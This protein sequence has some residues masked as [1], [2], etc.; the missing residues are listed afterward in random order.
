MPFLHTMI[1]YAA[2]R[3]GLAGRVADVGLR[4][5]KKRCVAVLTA[6]LCLMLVLGL[7]ACAGSGGGR[8]IQDPQAGTVLPEGAKKEE[9]VVLDA[10]DGPFIL[11]AAGGGEYVFRMDGA[12]D[13][14]EGGVQAGQYVRIWY[15]GVL[16]DT[17]ARNVKLLRIEAA[18]ETQPDSLSMG[19]TADGVVTAFDEESIT[20]RTAGGETYTFAAGRS[21]RA[22]KGE[23]REGMWARVYFD[24]A[25]D[26]AVVSRV[27]A[28]VSEGDVFTLAGRIRAVD[29]K[30]DTI[31][32]LADTGE[33]YIFALG[34]AEV[35]M[36]DGLRAGSRAVLSYSG[37]AAPED[38]SHAM[39]LRVQAEKLADAQAVRGTVCS[40][41]SKQGS[42]GVCTADGRVLAFYTGKSLTGQQGGVEPGDGVRVTYSGCISGESTRSAQ[43]L[44]LEVT[45]RKDANKSVVLGTVRAVSDTALTL[46]AADG[47]TL[48]FEAVPGKSFPE[49]LKKGDTVRVSYT[50]WIEGEDTSEAVY[51]SVSRAYA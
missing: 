9:G 48:K 18:Q 8:P 51:A 17:N 39:L 7:Q 46:A 28:R 4:A 31:T 25:P 33:R 19:S 36:P 10:S 37:S 40:V 34:F 32:F 45:A 6:A 12:E 27:T 30:A 14:V 42:I 11:R 15:D 21:V 29:E 50:G 44:S 5:M 20:L 49:E 16:T 43:L 47:R 1:K 22:L 35:D 13:M 38:T 2:D 24:G 23:P 41:N 26:G 3:G